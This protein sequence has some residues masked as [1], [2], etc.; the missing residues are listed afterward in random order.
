MYEQIDGHTDGTAVQTNQPTRHAGPAMSNNGD[1]TKKDNGT[2]LQAE[3]QG[4]ATYLDQKVR[5]QVL[6]LF[7][8]DK[9]GLQ[10]HKNYIAYHHHREA[11]LLGHIDKLFYDVQL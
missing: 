9:F 1:T 3:K 5:K 4:A 11:F 7:R 6:P 2:R 10:P 8:K